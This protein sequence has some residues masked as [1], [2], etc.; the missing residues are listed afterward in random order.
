MTTSFTDVTEPSDRKEVTTIEP[1]EVGN[2]LLILWNI[3]CI[4]FMSSF[5]DLR[6]ILGAHPGN[7]AT[8]FDSFGR[9]HEP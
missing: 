4:Y 8:V 7:K 5:D 1:V 6:D 2:F 3:F 9:S